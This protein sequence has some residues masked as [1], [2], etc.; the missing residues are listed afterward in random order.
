MK[1]QI[2]EIVAAYVRRNRVEA[3]Q[4]PGLIASVSQAFAN[5]GQPAPVPQAPSKLTAA[6]SI[7]R[8]VRPDAIICLDCGHSGRLLKRH[9]KTAHRLTIGEYRTRWGLPADYPVVAPNYAARRSALAKSL[10]LGRRPKTA[11]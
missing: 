1:E 11:N 8:S 9:L 7:R 3:G 10:G 2:A 5:L 4:L 6:V